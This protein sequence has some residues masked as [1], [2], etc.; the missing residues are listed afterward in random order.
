[1]GDEETHGQGRTFE[2]LHRPRDAEKPFAIEQQLDQRDGIQSQTAGTE[3]KVVREVGP[4]ARKRGS[5]A[6]EVADGFGD[7]F[8]VHSRALK[9]VLL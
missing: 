9:G 1:V 3:R 7:G 5:R 6:K 2:E 4:V 8:W